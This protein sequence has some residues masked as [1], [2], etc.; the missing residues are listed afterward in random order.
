MGTGETLATLLNSV[1]AYS[2]LL[3]IIFIRRRFNPTK[4]DLVLIRWSFLLLF[5]VG[6]VLYPAVW[7][8]R[9]VADTGKLKGPERK[10]PEAKVVI[11]EFDSKKATIDDLNR[12][13]IE[14][15]E[16]G[17]N[18][19]Q[20]PAG[21]WRWYCPG[22]E[23]LPEKSQFARME[24]KTAQMEEGII[25]NWLRA[26]RVKGVDIQMN[27][28]ESAECFFKLE[29]VLRKRRIANW[30]IADEGCPPGTVVIQETDR[31]P[32]KKRRGE[33]PS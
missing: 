24:V 7:R 17:A 16:K 30:L 26:N 5:L 12:V 25:L 10:E 33:K 22:C 21:Q 2:G 1:V 20:F 18:W 11:H 32:I 19:V 4:L 15:A 27:P 6:Q 3:L 29:A 28:G 31:M 13:L 14:A 23:Q 8:F 9:G